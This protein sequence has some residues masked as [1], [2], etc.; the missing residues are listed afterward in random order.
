M[1]SYQGS[2]KEG[3]VTKVVLRQVETNEECSCELDINP[4]TIVDGGGQ[5]LQ[6]AS[7]G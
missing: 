6:D 5:T 7:F 4:D 2:S 3:G 1:A